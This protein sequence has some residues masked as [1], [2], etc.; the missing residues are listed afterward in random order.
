VPLW[1]ARKVNAK[2]RCFAG[3]SLLLSLSITIVLFF[4]PSISYSED[5]P[6][7]VN[8]VKFGRE[9]VLGLIDWYEIAIELEGR[10]IPGMDT[11]NPRFLNNVGVRLNLCYKVNAISGKEFQYFQSTV[12]I[13]SLEKGNKRI[14]YFYL[15][16]EI[17]QRDRI[18]LNP[19][20]YL[21]EIEME[22]TPLSLGEKN[23]SPTLSDPSR[24]FNFKARVASEAAKNA[25]VLQP[26][27]HTP[28]YNMRKKLEESPSYYR[29]Y[30]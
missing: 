27:Y 21:V 17:I 16:P 23:I 5:A 11:L 15:P 4:I 10:R 30:N 14:S 2:I 20:A 3:Q 22:G 7:K 29:E 25:G 26:I 13:I 12:K 19:F 18:G 6:I 9:N 1:P 28:F 8:R 24:L